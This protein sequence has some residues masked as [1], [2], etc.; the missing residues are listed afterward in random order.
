VSGKTKLDQYLNC[1]EIVRRVFPVTTL[2][3]NQKIV[4]P[5]IEAIKAHT[6]AFL[7]IFLL[8]RHPRRDYLNKSIKGFVEGNGSFRAHLI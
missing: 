2:V 5:A 3:K 8:F 7:L 6:G 1:L 4:P